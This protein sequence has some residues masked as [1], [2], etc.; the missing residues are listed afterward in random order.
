MNK[1]N[2]L[3]WTEKYRPSQLEDIESNNKILFTL[4]CM[5]TLKVLLLDNNYIYPENIAHIKH[6]STEGKKIK[7]YK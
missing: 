5:F 7:L 4:I 2:N 6:N 3:P 1:S